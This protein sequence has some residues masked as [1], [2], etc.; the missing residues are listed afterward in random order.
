MRYQGKL[1]DWKDDKGFGFVIPNGGG[2]RAFVHIKA[3]AN[4]GRRPAGDE[5]ITY[6]LVFDPMGKAL[7]DNIEFYK[8]RTSTPPR[9]AGGRSKFALWFASLFVA[10]LLLGAASAKLPW[11]L[12]PVYLF[13]SLVA[14]LAYR[15]DKAAAEANRRRTPENTLLLIGLAGGWPGALAAQY[16]FRHKSKKTAFLVPFWFTVAL[17]G[18]ALGWLLLSDGGAVL[19]G[20]LG[21]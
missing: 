18:G 11:Q 12:L 2:Q 7:A 6:D 19:R 14:L 13:F 9:Q 17:N 8:E 21:A 1:H 15:S 3:F 16:L 20:A 4:R 5:I 10:L